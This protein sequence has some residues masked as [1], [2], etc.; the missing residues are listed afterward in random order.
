MRVARVLILLTLI[1]ATACGTSV[2]VQPSP[3]EPSPTSIPPTLTE[4]PPTQTAV[5]TS[6]PAK[7]VSLDDFESTETTWKAGI[8]PD[9]TDSSSLSIK[10]TGD[11]IS[12]GKQALQLNFKKNDQPKAIFFVDK[13][14]DLSQARFLQFDIFNPGSLASVGFAVTT[15]TGSVW[16]ESDSVPVDAGKMTTLSF[17][18]TASTYK[19][20]STN[21][22]FRAA[23]ADLNNVQRLAIIIYPAQSGSAYLDNIRL[24][25]TP[26]TP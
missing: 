15:G 3:P 16:Y 26:P 18:L 9:F 14:F 20:A 12:Q 24:S 13:P 4:I 2:T 25:N 22:E 6:L 5:P 10:L 21:W 7:V 8:A 19:A 1:L 23:I 17:D 11:H